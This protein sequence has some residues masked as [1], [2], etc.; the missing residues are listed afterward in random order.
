MN[1]FWIALISLEISTRRVDQKNGVS[2]K[3]FYVITI[4]QV[5]LNIDVFSED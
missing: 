4:I 3:Y 1:K 2:E 5:Y